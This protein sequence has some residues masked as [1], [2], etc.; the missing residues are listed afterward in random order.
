[1]SSNTVQVLISRRLIMKAVGHKLPRNRRVPRPL[2][3]TGLERE[4][5]M[6]ILHLIAPLFREVE[7]TLLPV[8]PDIISRHK[9]EMRVDAAAA[10]AVENYSQLISETFSG[11]KINFYRQ[12]TE[13]GMRL[14]AELFARRTATFNKQQ[15]DRQFRSVL[16]INPLLTERWL[17]PKV[18]AFVEQ[19]VSLIKSIPEEYLKKIESMVRSTVERGVS[20]EK[21]TQD[22]LDQFEVTRSRAHLI[23]R[24]QISKYNGKLTELRQREAGVSRYVWSTSK[25]ER[26][27]PKHTAVDGQIFSWDNPPPVG[28]DGEKLHPGEDYQCRCCALPILEEFL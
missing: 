24:D 25:D 28:N 6:A 5:Y 14:Q 17:E 4:Y 1:M 11:I 22:I 8:I 21:L 2:H 12:I 23:A 7:E 20:T 19:N 3:P 27:R 18:V 10:I 26:V 9:E 15:I 16:G 13:E